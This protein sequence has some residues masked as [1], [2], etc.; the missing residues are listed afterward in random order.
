MA[1]NYLNLVKISKIHV[2]RGFI[3]A[4]GVIPWVVMAFIVFPRIWFSSENLR[5][6][7]VAPIGRDEGFLGATMW[8]GWRTGAPIFFSIYGYLYSN[9]F[10]VTA[11]ILSFA[12]PITE[13]AAIIILRSINLLSYIL[14]GAITFGVTR[15]QFGAI[16]ALIFSWTLFL[17]SKDHDLIN[18]T[19]AI[20]TDVFN[21]LSII[22]S[23]FAILRLTSGVSVKKVSVAAFCMGTMM[24]VKYSGFMLLPF[25][26]LA[27]FLS[28]APSTSG[29]EF[30]AIELMVKKVLKIALS[31]ILL[32]ILSEI[33]FPTRIENGTFLGIL[34][35]EKLFLFKIAFSVIGVTIISLFINQICK[36]IYNKTLSMAPRKILVTIP[37]VSV[38]LLVFSL[39]FAALTSKSVFR[40]EFLTFLKYHMSQQQFFHSAFAEKIDIIFRQGLGFGLSL[41]WIIASIYFL[42][43]IGI[44]FPRKL[45]SSI[46]VTL[47]WGWI[48][49]IYFLFLTKGFD[50]RYVYLL[51]PPI[52][53]LV[54]TFISRVIDM[55]PKRWSGIPLKT[56]TMLVIFSSIFT[57]AAR[58]II[59]E[60]KYNTAFFTCLE[61]VPGIQAG[62]WLEK[63]FPSDMK[64]LQETSVY[65]PNTFADTKFFPWGDPYPFYKDFDPDIIFLTGQHV[66]Y[67]DGLRQ[68]DIDLYYRIKA[69]KTKTFITDLTKHKLK[70]RKVNNF[71]GFAQNED[72]MV[73]IKEK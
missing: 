58:I 2:L 60:Q 73:F 11:K 25:F 1:L 10:W 65:V 7:E 18:R 5:M 37:M 22:I 47:S 35:F 17:V 32:I 69:I 63:N 40:M 43:R 3:F 67:L 64:I 51:Y 38:G 55:I 12:V 23:F 33:F 4:L 36:K 46:I 8:G 56:I 41:A 70:Y 19:Y 34:H 30:I 66:R 68:D 59:N 49:L 16:L 20:Q 45:K 57:K 13:H 61:C 15:K 6:L 54:S 27:I 31:T 71:I 39:A 72:I 62:R 52:I 29:K 42:L 26:A 9:I 28:I 53:F 24:A 44:E 50:I 21:F 48:G 14:V